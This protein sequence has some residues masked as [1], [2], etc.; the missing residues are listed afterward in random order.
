VRSFAF[1]ALVIALLATPGIGR[2]QTSISVY[3]GTSEYDLSGVDSAPTTAVRAARH[4]SSLLVLEAGLSYVELREQFGRSNLYLPEAQLQLQWPLG[5]FAPYVG[6]GAGLGI[7]APEDR[8]FSNDTDATFSVGGGLRVDL[9]YRLL[10]AGDARIRTF[11]TRF[12]GTGAE[13]SL[14][15]G[16]R[17]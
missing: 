2:A 9:P 15:V 13:A 14:G 16:F 7:D 11:G 10:L 4:L 17:F 6:V 8:E 3:R 12:T 5:R 1:P